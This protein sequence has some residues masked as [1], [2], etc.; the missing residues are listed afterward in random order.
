MVDATYNGVVWDGSGLCCSTAATED[1]T[2]PIARPAAI[3]TM[4]FLH[5]YVANLGP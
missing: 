5:V 2:S 3:G 1:C 4:G